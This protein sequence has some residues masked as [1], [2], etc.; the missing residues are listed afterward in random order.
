VIEVIAHPGSARIAED[1]AVAPGARPELACRLEPP[2]QHPRGDVVGRHGL[3]V[4]DNLHLD[5]VAVLLDGC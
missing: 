4:V 5:L 2:D 1:A 3:W